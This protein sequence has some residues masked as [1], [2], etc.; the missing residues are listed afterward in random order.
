ME[1]VIYE[2]SVK[3]DMNLAANIHLVFVHG[4]HDGID[5]VN[6]RIPY[7]ID[8]VFYLAVK[9]FYYE[10]K[11]YVIPYMILVFFVHLCMHT[12]THMKVHVPKNLHSGEFPWD[13]INDFD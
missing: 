5:L 9:H 2:Q 3:S 4:M 12:N 8:N 13:G 10:D 6:P 7:N 1:N 11:S